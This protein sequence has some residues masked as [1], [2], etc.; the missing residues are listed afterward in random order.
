MRETGVRTRSEKSKD[1][2]RDSTHMAL[3]VVMSSVALAQL[4]D[5]VESLGELEVRRRIPL[6]EFG[7]PGSAELT[8]VEQW[9]SAAES[10]RKVASE[11][12][13][14]ERESAALYEAKKA[15]FFAEY[16]NRLAETANSLASAANW[17]AALANIIAVA[18]LIV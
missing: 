15:N 13:A 9:L 14:E 10:A 7:S 4:F 11:S 17:R 8:A 12:R 5:K 3:P 2:R 1:G 16:A 18:A 6:G